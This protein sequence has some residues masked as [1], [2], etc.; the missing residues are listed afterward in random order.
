MADA[1]DAKGI[2]Y[3]YLAFEGEQHGF[4]QASSVRRALEAELYFYGRIL[5]FEPADRVE[6]VAIRNL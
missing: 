5:G 4:R 1:L 6:P 3:A 2:P